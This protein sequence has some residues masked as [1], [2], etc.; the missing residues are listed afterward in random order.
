MTF[1]TR[2]V[3]MICWMMMRSL[4]PSTDFDRAA[5]LVD[6]DPEVG[7]DL[8]GEPLSLAEQAEQEV[9][10]PDVGMA[11]ALRLFLGEGED[12]LRPLGE[13]LKWVP[14]CLRAP[15]GPT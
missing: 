9:L 10:G 7:Q 12:L 6:L 13:P 3:G 1:F 11:R 2:E 14:D 5:H 15:A 4:R 8:G